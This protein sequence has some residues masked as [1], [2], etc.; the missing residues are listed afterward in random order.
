MKPRNTATIIAITALLQ[1][2]GAPCF[3]ADDTTQNPPVK[4]APDGTKEAFIENMSTRVLGV[5]KDQ[6]KSFK[7]RQ[8]TLRALFVE[9]VDTDWI[10]QFVLGAT[11]KTATTEQRARYIELYRTYLTETYISK[12]DEDSGSKVKDIK[13]KNIKET[14]DGA[15]TA[16]TEII[17][18]SNEPIVKVDYMLRQEDGQ[19]KVIDIIIEGV[20]L[21]TT[22]RQEL[23]AIAGKSG[24][25]GVLQKL[26]EVTTHNK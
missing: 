6:Q 11:W 18:N 10:A 2:A 4:A 8:N 22:H 14:S 12:F 7:E 23:S 3:A 20:S 26:S 19:F 16:H 15:F 21:L 13:I 9:V 24:I 17:Q 1:L 5:L 25:D